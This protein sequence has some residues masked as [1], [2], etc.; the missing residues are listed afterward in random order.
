MLI[1][2][3]YLGQVETGRRNFLILIGPYGA[4]A[5]RH[6]CVSK[7]KYLK[8]GKSHI[9]TL[10]ASKH[11]SKKFL[12]TRSIILSTH[13]DYRHL[14]YIIRDLT[15]IR[16]TMSTDGARKLCPNMPCTEKLKGWGVGSV[17]GPFFFCI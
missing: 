12:M 10:R 14:V 4:L 7:P 15:A 9:F 8:T 6:D 2:A 17:C 3:F 5:I 11:L 1:P 16:N 13:T